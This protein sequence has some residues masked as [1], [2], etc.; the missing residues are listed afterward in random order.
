MRIPVDSST[1]RIA[2]TSFGMAE[3]TADSMQPMQVLHARVLLANDLDDTPWKFDARTTLLEIGELVAPP[4]FVNG[5]AA[6]TPTIWVQRQ[7]Q[8]ELDLYFPVPVTVR[9]D[10]DIARFA[11]AWR[12]QVGDREVASSTG[13]DGVETDLPGQEART[14][15]SRRHWWADPEYPWPQFYR[16]PGPVVHRPPTNIEVTRAPRGEPPTPTPC[17]QW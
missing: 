8:R 15:G 7:Q 5:D 12:V 17:D 3:L 16:R 9:R 2:I 13:F 14:I 6:T 4:I 1:G 10:E 11:I